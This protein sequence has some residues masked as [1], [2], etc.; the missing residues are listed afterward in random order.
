[1]NRPPCPRCQGVLV[2]KHGSYTKSSGVVVQRWFC[3]A[4]RKGFNPTAQSPVPNA[5]CPMPN[6]KRSPYE[7]TIAKINHG[8]ER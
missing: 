6:E 5:Q 7:W 4:S 1:M 3:Q 8:V 2:F